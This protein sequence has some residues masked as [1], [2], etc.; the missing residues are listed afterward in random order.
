MTASSRSRSREQEG[1]RA[2]S[3]YEGAIASE[4]GNFEQQRHMGHTDSVVSSLAV[5]SNS[6]AKPMQKKSS[7]HSILTQSTKPASHIPGNF[8]PN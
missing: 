8:M 2:N 6:G 3:P 1:A 7:V 4:Y 5:Q